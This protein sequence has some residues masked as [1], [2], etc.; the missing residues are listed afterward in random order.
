MDNG[1]NPIKEEEKVL[2][3]GKKAIKEEKNVFSWGKNYE[4]KVASSSS[5]SQV[6]LET[7]SQQSDSYSAEATIVLG[8]MEESD[9][10]DGDFILKLLT[11]DYVDASPAATKSSPVAPT[12]N[13]AP[14]TVAQADKA[15]KQVALRTVVLTPP[16]RAP[17]S[18]AKPFE[19]RK[20][21]PPQEL[22]NL[23]KT[24][25]KRATRI[26]KNRRSAIRAKE[27][28]KLYTYTLQHELQKLK[29]RAAQ[30]SIQLT[31]LGT[32]H[33]ALIDENSKLKDRVHF[34]KRM[35]ALQESKT[36]ETRQEIQ[37]YKLL[38]AR[39]MRGAVDGNR[40]SF[41]A[42]SAN[43]NAQHHAVSP[44]SAA[45]QGLNLPS[46]TTHVHQR[47]QHDSQQPRDGQRP[48]QVRQP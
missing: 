2:S 43:V 45:Q 17:A 29:S 6:K 41:S 20:A 32:Q 25:P 26:I 12:S 13:P 15:T 4:P 18:I 10:E 36:D 19:I 39:Q 40:I 47:L 48:N 37:F 3:L 30:S 22:E 46:Q 42:P 33:N 7:V 31:L 34:V 11:T 9:D 24:D 16:A 1:K 5:K 35:I 44:S 8:E 38:L 23:A 21:M 14:V 28:K 27:R